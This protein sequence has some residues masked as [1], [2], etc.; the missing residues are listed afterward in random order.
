MYDIIQIAQ[1][2]KIIDGIKDPQIKMDLCSAFETL[3]LTQSN[4][5]HIAFAED[6]GIITPRPEDSIIGY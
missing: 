1:I 6:C 4:F 3:F 2:A 5:D